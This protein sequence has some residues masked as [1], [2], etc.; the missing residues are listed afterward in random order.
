[1]SNRLLIPALC[2]LCQLPVMAQITFEK[3]GDFRGTVKNA[4]DTWVEAETCIYSYSLNGEHL[5]FFRGQRKSKAR[6]RI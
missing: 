6:I 3:A 1:M 2:C 5:S 4:V